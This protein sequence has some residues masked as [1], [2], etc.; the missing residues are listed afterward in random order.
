MVVCFSCKFLVHVILGKLKKDEAFAMDFWKLYTEGSP[1][2]LQ[3]LSL[4]LSRFRLAL[5]TLLSGI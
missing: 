1:A 4:S 2:H 5:D 3:I